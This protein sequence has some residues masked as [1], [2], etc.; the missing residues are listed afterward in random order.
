MSYTQSASLL[1]QC[2]YEISIYPNVTITL[3]LVVSVMSPFLD[4]IS[5]SHMLTGVQF[6]LILQRASG[7]NANLYL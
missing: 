7:L 5:D 6:L 3:Y 4:D 2:C 1:G